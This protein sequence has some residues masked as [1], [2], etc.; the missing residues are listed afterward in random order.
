M[1]QGL[2]FY[3]KYRELLRV[4]TSITLFNIVRIFLSIVSKSM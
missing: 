4:L 1:T 2:N 3:D